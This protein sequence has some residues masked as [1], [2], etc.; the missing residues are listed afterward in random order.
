MGIRT[1][2]LDLCKTC[3]KLFLKTRDA[4]VCPICAPQKY[5]PEFTV[6]S[7]SPHVPLT[8]KEESVKKNANEQKDGKWSRKY[9]C[10]VNCGRNDVK[11]VTRGLCL[12]CY[13]RDRKKKSWSAKVR[14]RV[15][16][17]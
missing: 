5:S 4:N 3:G 13:Q 8:N 14:K 11:H 1:E 7:E 17:I 10:C 2:K 6:Q 9:D 16:S 15:G 12:N